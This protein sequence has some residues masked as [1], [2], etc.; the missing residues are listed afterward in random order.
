MCEKI[1]GSFA[2]ITG[3]T[4]PTCKLINHARTKPARDR[5]FHAEHVAYLEGGKN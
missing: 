2:D 1:P 4:A 3:I 5:V